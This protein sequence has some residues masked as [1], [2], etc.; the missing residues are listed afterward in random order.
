[1][2]YELYWVSGSPYSWRTLLA[3]AVK[4]VDYD[5]K[6]LQASEGEHK[7]PQFLKLNPRGKVPVLTCGETVIYESLAILSY[8][9]KKH[10]APAL[11]GTTPEQ[12]ARIWRTVSEVESYVRPLMAAMAGPILFGGLDDRIE[13]IQAAATQLHGELRTFD[14]ALA[15][16][17]F[18]ADD[19]ISAADCMLFPEVQII[20]RAMTKPEVAPLDLGFIPFDEWYPN[21]SVWVKRIEALP[22]Y[23]KTY[24][25]HWRETV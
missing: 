17:Q 2:A 14:E 22:G 11:F 13:E 12:T 7:T 6:L 16:K 20:F 9:D 15:T 18:L 1:M 10:P 23:D 19:A 3:L 5:I 24:P 4:G 8:L 25:P 21:L